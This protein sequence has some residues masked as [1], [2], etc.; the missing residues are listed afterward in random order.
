MSRADRVDNMRLRRIGYAAT[1]LFV[2]LFALFVLTGCDGKQEPGISVPSVSP[3]ERVT[4]ANDPTPDKPN[5][6]KSDPSGDGAFR[7]SPE[8]PPQ[9][10][11]P[12]DSPATDGFTITDNSDTAGANEANGAKDAADATA[13]EDLESPGQDESSQPEPNPEPDP[14]FA[15]KP[16]TVNTLDSLTHDEGIQAAIKKSAEKYG[17]VGVQVAVIKNGEIAGA[18]VYGDATKKSM[19]MDMDTKI[20][21]ASISKVV[22]TMLVMRLGELGYIDIDSD[23]SRYWDAMIRN[24]NHDDTPVTIRHILSHTSSILAYD[25]GFNADGDLIRLRFLDGSC[26]GRNEPGAISSW[27]YNNY[28]F[29]ALGVT[30]EVYMGETINSLASSYL[31]DP[32]GIDAAFGTGSISDTDRLATIYTSGGGVGLS[33]DAQKRS[34]GS[35]YPGERGEEFPGGL[36]IS[37]YDLAKLIAVLIGNGEYNGVRLLSHESVAL[38]ETSQGRTGGFEQCLP[39]RRRANLYG[40]DELYYHTG[41]NYGI[42]NLVSFDPASGD[43]VIVLT[44]GADGRKDSNDIYAICGEITEY[45]YRNP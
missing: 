34:L 2:V 13:S 44:S 16:V 35:T 4:P 20:R 8:V 21:I 45:I 17:A 1:I 5:G 31:F 28:A 27:N 40:M 10:P 9:Q 30:I 36:A 24:P 38:M 12:V 32:F 22:L 26:F 19:P 43:G 41:S 29:A 23:I 6:S 15:P 3:T 33:V 39:L 14:T 11:E 18:Y 42:F 25:Y 37:A 7:V